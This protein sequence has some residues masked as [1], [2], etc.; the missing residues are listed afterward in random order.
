M[1][2]SINYLK[3]HGKNFNYKQFR[4]IIIQKTFLKK[5]Y[6]NHMRIQKKT[7]LNNTKCEKNVLEKNEKSS[8][9]FL[10]TKL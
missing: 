4:K 10:H 6:S 1:Q 2:I 7:I 8:V 9:K 5:E 3:K